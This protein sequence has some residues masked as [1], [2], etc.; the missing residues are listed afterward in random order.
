MGMTLLEIVCP[1]KIVQH[2]T[3]SFILITLREIDILLFYKIMT[4]TDL[5]LLLLQHAQY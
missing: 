4:E 5:C 1:V 3:L 2:A